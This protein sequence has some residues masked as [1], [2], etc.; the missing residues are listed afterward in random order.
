MLPFCISESNDL[1]FLNK[2]VG[3][4]GDCETARLRD[5]ETGGISVHLRSSAFI[6]G[7]QDRSKALTVTGFE[8]ER[9]S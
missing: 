1:R 4:A 9:M 5:C 3:T 8:I 7:K 6:C 2:Y